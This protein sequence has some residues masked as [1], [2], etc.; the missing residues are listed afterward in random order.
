MV[1][2]A[3][4]RLQ[5]LARINPSIDGIVA[6]A[7]TEGGGPGEPNNAAEVLRALAG[8]IVHPNVGAVLAVDY[9]VEPVSNSRLQGFLRERGY[10]LA[11]VPH[12]FLSIRAG[13]AAALG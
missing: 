4:P 2:R 5:P 13:L 1:A 8:F 12:H 3:L 6:I 11:E 10:P 7:H 9:G